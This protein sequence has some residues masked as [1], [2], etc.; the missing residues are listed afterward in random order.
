MAKRQNTKQNN[1]KFK[2]EYITCTVSLQF[3]ANQGDGVVVHVLNDGGV[4]EHARALIYRNTGAG[5]AIA[6]DS[7]SVAVTPSWQ[8]G[9][10][11]TIPESGEYWVRVRATS[12]F[13]VP[14]VLF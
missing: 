1:A 11:F 5:A 13:L 7:G 2:F 6:A 10:G 9:L 14:K 12:E 4:S 3:V 8:W